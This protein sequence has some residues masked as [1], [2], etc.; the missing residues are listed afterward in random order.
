MSITT[1]VLSFVLGGDAAGLIKTCDDGEKALKGLTE[2]T[3]SQLQQASDAANLSLSEVTNI[4]SKLATTLG[5]NLSSAATLLNDALQNPIKGLDA[6]HAAGLKVTEAQRAEM[7]SY[8]ANGQSLNAHALIIGEITER[9]DLLNSSVADLDFSGWDN[10]AGDTTRLDE[11]TE[12]EQLTRDIEETNKQIAEDYSYEAKLL[13]DLNHKFAEQAELKAKAELYRNIPTSKGGPLTN[14]EH[15][16]KQ[17]A[18]GGGSGLG[19]T[20]LAFVGGPVGATTLALGIAAAAATKSVTAFAEAETI[21]V[22]LESVLKATGNAAGFTADQLDE[23]ARGLQDTTRF[24]GSSAKEAMIL[25]STMKNIKGDNF[26]QTLTVAADLAAVMGT[27]LTG[28]AETLGRALTNPEQAS[29]R[30]AKA[31]IVLTDRQQQQI[32]SF[33]KLNDV[34]SAQKIILDEVASRTG[35][36]AAASADTLSGKWEKLKNKVGDLGEAIGE[37]LSGPTRFILGYWEMLAFTAEKALSPIDSMTEAWLRSRIEINRLAGDMEKVI[38]LEA[39]LAAMKSPGGEAP[40]DGDAA[41]KSGP[42]EAERARLADQKRRYAASQEE[43]KLRDEYERKYGLTA[44]DG[45]ANSTERQIANAAKD[46]QREDRSKDRASQARRAGD[47]ASPSAIDNTQ[48]NNMALAV[49]GLGPMQSDDGTDARAALAAAGKEN[50]LAMVGSMK[51]E[52]A[53][54]QSSGDLQFD[55]KKMTLSDQSQKDLDNILAKYRANVSLMPGYNAEAWAK[56]EAIVQENLRKAAK[57]TGE[58]RALYLQNADNAIKASEKM[59]EDYFAKMEA[60]KKKA[61]EVVDLNPADI[62]ARFGGDL[63]AVKRDEAVS[64]FGE[65]G[66]EIKSTLAP[67]AD[68]AIDDQNVQRILNNYKAMLSQMPGFSAPIFAQIEKQVVENAHKAME[69]TGGM[70]EMYLKRLEQTLADG[71]KVFEKKAKPPEAKQVDAYAQMQDATKAQLQAQLGSQMQ[72]MQGALQYGMST[73]QRQGLKALQNEWAVAMRRVRDSTGEARAANIEEVKRINEAWA[74]SY[75]AIRDGSKKTV[76]Q[77]VGDAKQQGKAGT[78]GAKERALSNKEKRQNDIAA[79]AA[80]DEVMRSAKPMDA[81]FAMSRELS[82]IFNGAMGSVGTGSAMLAQVMQQTTDPM[83]KLALESDNLKAKLAMAT[84]NATTFGGGIQ[85]MIDLQKELNGLQQKK[86][87]IERQQQAERKAAE[88]RRNENYKKR[89]FEKDLKAREERREAGYDLASLIA[90]GDKKQ[91]TTFN[92]YGAHDAREILNNVESAMKT[93]GYNR[94][95]SRTLDS[96][97]S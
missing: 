27:D 91:N 47:I 79:R 67:G 17:T 68:G 77:L 13:D 74:K 40:S 69:T 38:E 39:E 12:A 6:L 5:T 59:Y 20:A 49:A 56:T 83:Q 65:M 94:G 37:K 87:N 28:A 57:S 96:K 97:G 11:L 10:F 73:E 29:G 85:Q 52:I 93:R 14:S 70:R 32:A 26:K 62:A 44:D 71:E 86:M 64:T 88:D 80:N 95:I 18:S 63:G 81:I 89:Q 92:I 2:H 82:G 66:G 51:A 21:N 25:L 46:K 36:A 54:F 8:A 50:V 55:W 31:G 84:Y 7:E 90:V 53:S 42:T 9:Y 72:G 3:K 45:Y 60:A 1:E 16:A 4:A 48:Q 30:L 75:Q 33:M 35:G 58:Q 61:A 19:A 22:R 15:A 23:M 34:A 41:K 78:E 24:A 43:A 76:E